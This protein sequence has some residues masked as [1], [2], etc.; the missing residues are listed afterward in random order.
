MSK[1]KEATKEFY[2]L[3]KKT[4][5]MSFIGFPEIEELV[6]LMRMKD[7]EEIRKLCL[8]KRAFFKDMK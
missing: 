4:N 5:V 7:T 1:D 6:H 8:A 3:Y 2:L